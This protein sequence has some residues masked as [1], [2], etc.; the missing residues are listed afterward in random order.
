MSKEIRIPKQKRSIEKR[1]KIIEVAYQLFMDNGYFNTSTVDIT[2]AASLSVGIFYAYFTDKKDILLICLERFGTSF[3]EEV[4]QKIKTPST[5]EDIE[6]IIKQML[7]IMVK[8]HTQKR[9]YHDEVKALQLLDADVKKHFI[10]V[11]QALME[12]F[13]KRLSYYNYHFPYHA[14]QVFLIHQMIEGIEDELVFKDIKEIDHNIL[15]NQCAH[16][17][18]SM[19]VKD[20]I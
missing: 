5:E 7:Y 9:R 3:V 6:D 4:Y 19:L 8:S 10:G 2:K 11:S 17:I 14:E 1:E 16:I 13:Q 12:A 20:D 18:K 15:I